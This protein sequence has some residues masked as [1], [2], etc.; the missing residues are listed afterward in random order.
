MCILPFVLSS[1]WHTVS[2]QHFVIPHSELSIQRYFIRRYIRYRVSNEGRSSKK[3]L[4]VLAHFILSHH[5]ILIFFKNVNSSPNC[6]G[7]RAQSYQLWEE[8]PPLFLLSLFGSKVWTPNRF[9]CHFSPVPDVWPS[10]PFHR[11]NR[12]LMVLTAYGALS[13]N[14][15]ISSWNQVSSYTLWVLKGPLGQETSN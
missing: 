6:H 3:F 10:S 14:S 12:P 5:G 1:W 11:K 8:P 4:Y 7:G 13:S 15:L 9:P 2:G